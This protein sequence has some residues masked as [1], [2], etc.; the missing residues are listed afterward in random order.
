MVR[1]ANAWVERAQLSWQNRRFEQAE[2]EF[3]Q[4]GGAPYCLMTLGHD[5]VLR[6]TASYRRV[7]CATAAQHVRAGASATDTLPALLLLHDTPL[8]MVAGHS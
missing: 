4:V 7:G 1:A 5:G 8:R 3:T 2:Q 6:I